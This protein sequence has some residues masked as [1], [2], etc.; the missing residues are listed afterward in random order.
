MSWG[1]ERAHRAVNKRQGCCVCGRGVMLPTV[2]SFCESVRW[3]DGVYLYVEHCRGF[4]LFHL[5]G[6]TAGCSSLPPLLQALL[7]Q[8]HTGRCHDDYMDPVQSW[9]HTNVLRNVPSLR[10]LLKWNLSF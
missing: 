6:K 7:L 8:L 2:S 5:H 4:P 1:R 10:S 3:T 9:F